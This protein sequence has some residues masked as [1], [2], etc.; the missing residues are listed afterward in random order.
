MFDKIYFPQ[1]LAFCNVSSVNFT[2]APFCVRVLVSVR[3]FGTGASPSIT[4]GTLG[5][6]C[7]PLSTYQGPFDLA[8]TAAGLI[9]NNTNVYCLA[10]PLPQD[11]NS[12]IT[13]TVFSQV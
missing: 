4:V 9:T 12:N 3:N 10:P 7:S 8:D 13:V 1:L 11:G 2:C 6:V 5:A